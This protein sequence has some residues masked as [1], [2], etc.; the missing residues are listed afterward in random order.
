MIEQVQILNEEAAHEDQ[1]RN[2]RVEIIQEIGDLERERDKTTNKLRRA[3]RQTLTRFNF[4]VLEDL[5][6][7][8]THFNSRLISRINDWEDLLD[9]D[10]DG[11]PKYPLQGCLNLATALKDKISLEKPV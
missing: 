9:T 4:G 1:R 2:L 3:S 10:Q 5:F 6:R 11:N 8:T 7:R